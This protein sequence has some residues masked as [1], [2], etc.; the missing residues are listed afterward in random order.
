MSLAFSEHW[1]TGN[2]KTAVGSTQ[3]E[4]LIA[5]QLSDRLDRDL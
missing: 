3:S 1:L 5:S 2:G 4:V